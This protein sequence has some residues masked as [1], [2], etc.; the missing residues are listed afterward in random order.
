[1][2]YTPNK[3]I[4]YEIIGALNEARLPI[5]FKGA[6]VTNV[7]LKENDSPYIRRTT[8]ELQI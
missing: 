6:N 4:L 5:I 8:E 1:M 7:I 2:K 3:D